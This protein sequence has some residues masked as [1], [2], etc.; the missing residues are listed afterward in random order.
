[1]LFQS[2]LDQFRMLFGPT[3]FG[4]PITYSVK[5]H[6]V[7]MAYTDFGRDSV[8]VQSKGCSSQHK[9][10]LLASRCHKGAVVPLCYFRGWHE[11]LVPASLRLDSVCAEKV[12][13][14]WHRVLGRLAGDWGKGGFWADP[15]VEAGFSLW[16]GS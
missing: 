4:S 1:M 5:T 10:L 16:A 6:S 13:Q 9:L 8:P 2:I 15:W 7:I 3:W 14:G 11:E 12:L